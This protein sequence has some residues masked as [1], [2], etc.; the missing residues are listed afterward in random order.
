MARLDL[1]C[2]MWTFSSCSKREQLSGCHARASRSG[3]FS[4]CGAQALG[5]VG[6]VAVAC[7]L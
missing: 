1:F 4:C 5:R 6:S 7:G 3:G 2:C